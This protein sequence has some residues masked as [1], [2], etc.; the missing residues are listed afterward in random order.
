MCYL[1]H[2][3]IGGT[4]YEYGYIP[5]RRRCVHFTSRNAASGVPDD[6][7]GGMNCNNLVTAKRGCLFQ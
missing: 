4:A 7:S 2:P 5:D 3:P 6:F 1:F